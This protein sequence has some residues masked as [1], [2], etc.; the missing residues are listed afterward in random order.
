[1]SPGLVW[2]RLLGCILAGMLV[3]PAAC[4]LRPLHRIRPVLTE[5]LTSLAVGVCWLWTSFGLCRGDLR[6][7]YFFGMIAGWLLWEWLFGTAATAVFRRF[8][9]I[10]AF[11][12]RIFLNFFR[13][14][15]NFLFARRKK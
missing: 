4:A 7:G 5:L 8:W 12:L 10:A 3:G 13:K 14:I 6:M 2:H 11:P 9:H 1:M 15:V